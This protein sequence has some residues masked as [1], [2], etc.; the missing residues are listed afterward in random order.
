M[1]RIVGRKVG[2]NA[3]PGRAMVAAAEQELRADVDRA[4]FVRRK[5]DR[6]VPIVAQL[7]LVAAL[8]L[9]IALL[10]R[11]AVDPSDVTALVFGI[12]KV[13]VGRIGEGPEA[14][15]AEQILPAAVGDAPWIFAVA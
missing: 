7:L 4:L 15:T 1:N 6:R 8:G 13:R 11:V 14:V 2:R 5:R 9:D 10:E 12:S 3:V